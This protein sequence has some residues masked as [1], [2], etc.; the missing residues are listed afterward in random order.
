MTP[1]TRSFFAPELHIP[2]GTTNIDFY[3]DFGAKE[4]FCFR[5]DDG[6]IHVVELEIDGAIFHL[7]VTMRPTIATSSLV[8]FKANDFEYGAIIGFADIVDIQPYGREHEDDVK[9]GRKS[10]R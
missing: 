10:L 7:H 5:N 3:L 8:A 6:S 1:N 2:N 4:H 9:T